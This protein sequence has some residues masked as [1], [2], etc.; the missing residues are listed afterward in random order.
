METLHRQ[1]GDSLEFTGPNPDFERRRRNSKSTVRA[2]LCEVALAPVHAVSTCHCAP[3]A[4]C[5]LGNQ[6][7]AV[8]RKDYP[9][10]SPHPLAIIEP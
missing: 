1:A 4:I 7:R 2:S 8:R 9:Q 5:T 6:L 3:T 10:R